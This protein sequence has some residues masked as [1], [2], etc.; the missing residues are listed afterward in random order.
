M[1]CLLF[2]LQ[3]VKHL[4]VGQ[5]RAETRAH[6][7]NENCLLPAQLC[8]PWAGTDAQVTQLS[9]LETLVVASLSGWLL[10][11][12]LGLW[13]GPGQLAA[14]TVIP[15][16][17][18]KDASW[19]SMSSCPAPFQSLGFLKIRSWARESTA[20]PDSLG[21]RVQFL[22]LSPSKGSVSSKGEEELSALM[23]RERDSEMPTNET[24]GVSSPTCL[25]W[26][27][28]QVHAPLR[29]LFFPTLKKKKKKRRHWKYL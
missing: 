1:V 28:K 8:C 10:P 12:P 16:I 15:S 11:Y 14:P 25:L 6:S 3:T 2:L 21:G 29:C 19:K 24:P 13:G 4:R 5:Q 26:D 9:I 20:Q 17:H 22:W 18:Q 23:E 27:P 7:L